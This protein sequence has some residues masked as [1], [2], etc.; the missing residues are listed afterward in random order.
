MRLYNDICDQYYR[1]VNDEVAAGQQFDYLLVEALSQQHVTPAA[2]AILG[3]PDDRTVTL[4]DVTRPAVE[5]LS[6]LRFIYL[7]S[8]LE[9]FAQ[10]YIAAREGIPSD[11]LRSLL[12]PEMAAWQHANSGPRAST[13]FM[14]VAFVRFVIEHRYSLGFAAVK[15]SCFWEAGSL[16]HCVVHCRG[17]VPDAPYLQALSATLAHTGVAPSIGQPIAVTDDLLWRLIDD[18]RAFVAA[19]DFQ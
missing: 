16:R 11:R 15:S 4:L 9:A 6:R 1:R 18:Y 12:A 7:V 19:C 10:D 5:I 17:V 13:S 2:K 8:L 3:L 14:N